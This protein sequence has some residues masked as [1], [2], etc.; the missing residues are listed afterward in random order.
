MGGVTDKVDD[1]KLG[2]ESI[3]KYYDYK[4]E[5]YERKYNI[6]YYTHIH[7]GLYDPEDFPFLYRRDVDFKTLGL[8][9]IKYLLF[10]G[11]EN[12]TRYACK[13]FS[14]GNFQKVLDV[15]CGHGGTCIYLAQN[16]SIMVVG[17]TV[18]RKQ[19]SQT[20][21]FVRTAGLK[22]WIDVRL[23]NARECDFADAEFDG[24]IAIDSFCH[25]GDF[26][27]LFSVLS[28]IMRPSGRLVICDY[29]IDKTSSSF[30]ERFDSYWVADVSTLRQLLDAACE[31]FIIK[32]VKELTSDQIPF[33]KLSIAYTELLPST[34][35][36]EGNQ[37]EQ[38]R[39]M[40]SLCY[41]KDLLQAFLN[42]DMYY[43]NLV[44]EKSV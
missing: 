30:K 29:F 6:G 23:M 28:R 24:V 34:K 7:T 33:W 38:Q 27:K 11:Q 1:S 10:V 39:L 36:I 16:Y 19:V 31:G 25:I 8:E 20:T 21:R 5:S 15:G 14:V 41:H 2:V 12:L 32:S 43:Y 40:G 35:K 17:I 13:N 9:R 18:S 37:R 22:H 4:C 42:G 26:E 3:A 44:L